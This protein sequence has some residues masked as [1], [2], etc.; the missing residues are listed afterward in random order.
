MAW[1]NDELGKPGIQFGKAVIMLFALDK[2][3]WR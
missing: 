3:G 2:T 1:E